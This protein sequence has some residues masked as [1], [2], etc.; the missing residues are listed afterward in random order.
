[1]DLLVTSLTTD[2]NTPKPRSPSILFPDIRPPPPAT[3]QRD[4]RDQEDSTDRRSDSD[5]DYLVLVEP[6]GETA[7]VTLDIWWAR[8]SEVIQESLAAGRVNAFQPDLDKVIVGFNDFR[9][10]EELDVWVGNF[11][12]LAIDKVTEIY[13]RVGVSDWR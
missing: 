7:T 8:G 1:M 10:W 6:G 12:L 3:A 9:G 5:E 2:G 13:E 4:D 11:V